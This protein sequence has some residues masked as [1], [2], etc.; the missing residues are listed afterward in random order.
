MNSVRSD[1]LSLKYQRF[2]LSGCKDIGIRKLEYGAKAQFPLSG[3][4]RSII[5][6]KKKKVFFNTKSIIYLLRFI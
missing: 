4:I 6:F 1:N 2:I 3:D 5:G